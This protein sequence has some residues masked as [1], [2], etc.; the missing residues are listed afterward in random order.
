V[1]AIVILSPEGLAACTETAERLAF[2]VAFAVNG[3]GQ[4]LGRA[5]DGADGTSQALLETP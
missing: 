5:P 1:I 2:L 4:V 3:A